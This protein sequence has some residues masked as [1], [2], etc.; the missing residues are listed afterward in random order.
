[1]IILSVA[2]S[3]AAMDKEKNIEKKKEIMTKIIFDF[4]LIKALSD[5]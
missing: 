4:L 1:M 2:Q 3:S 5:V